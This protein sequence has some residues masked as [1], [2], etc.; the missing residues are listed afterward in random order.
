MKIMLRSR[1]MVM[2]AYFE[3]SSDSCVAKSVGY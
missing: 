1:V 3:G 2:F